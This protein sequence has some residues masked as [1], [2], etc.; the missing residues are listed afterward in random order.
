MHVCVMRGEHK[1]GKHSLNC[2]Q[3]THNLNPEAASMTAYDAKYFISSSKS[4]S[5]T[6]DPVPSISRLNELCPV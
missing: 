2:E 5:S 1:L 4:A 3:L 6:P